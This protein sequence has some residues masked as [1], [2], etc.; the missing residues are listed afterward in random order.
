MSCCVAGAVWP[1]PS[2]VSN[3]AA[4]SGTSS[5][6]SR[7]QS[8]VPNPTMMFDPPA[9]TGRLAQAP[10]RGANLGVGG[11]RPEIELEVVVRTRA[12]GED[13][14]LRNCHALLVLVGGQE[15]AGA[16][17]VAVAV[18]SVDAAHRRP[19]LVRRIDGPGKRGELSRVGTSPV[20]DDHVGRGW[21]AWRSGLSSTGHSP[22]ST[23]W[24]SSRMA[25]IA[26]QKRSSSARS[27]DSVGSTISVPATG[28]DTVGVEAVVDEALGDVVD[29]DAGGLRDRAQVEDAL[30]RDHARR[31]R[32]RAP[33]S[34]GAAARHVVGVE[35]RDLRRPEQAVGAHHLDVRRRDRQD[36]GRAPRCAGDVSGQ[37]RARCSRTATG[38]TP[39]PPR[40]AGCRTS[41]AG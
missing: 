3:G 6:R 24:I 41:C 8:S 5:G 39:G 37:E 38:P 30:V 28:N 31:A 26:S 29:G 2:M 19:V 13:A 35:D 11:I 4:S 14:G 12:L 33:D 27:S 15:R 25:I 22:R 9:V 23:A 7:R 16:Y 36:A 32:R 10:D 17:E 1:A 20:V 40:R 21:G 18:G 34:A